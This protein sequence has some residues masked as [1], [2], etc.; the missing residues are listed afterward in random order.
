MVVAVLCGGGCVVWWWL[1]CV[2][3]VA[4]LCNGG[5]VVWWWLCC[6]VVVAVI[7]IYLLMAIK[8][9]LMVEMSGWCIVKL[10]RKTYNKQT[11]QRKK[12]QQ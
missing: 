4:V 11:A 9:C 2:V 8:W 1:C 10:K 12:K 5:C 3:V 7:I 6:V